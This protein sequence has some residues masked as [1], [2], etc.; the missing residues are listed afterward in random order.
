MMKPRGKSSCAPSPP[1]LFPRFLGT[2]LNPDGAHLVCLS[3]PGI[4]PIIRSNLL[5]PDS[6]I[7]TKV[8]KKKERGN[9]PGACLTYI[10]VLLPFAAPT[11]APAPPCPLPPDSRVLEDGGSP[12]LLLDLPPP[13]PLP[14]RL[15]GSPLHPPPP[16]PPPLPLP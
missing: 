5:I 4:P 15:R 7:F 9:T 10:P 13:P 1:P 16:P 2:H 12:R 6:L 14:R 8:K 3:I 11:T